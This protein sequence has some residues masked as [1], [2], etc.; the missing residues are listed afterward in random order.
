MYLLLKVKNKR[1]LLRVNQRVWLELF[2]WEEA[3]HQYSECTG[4]LGPTLS[5]QCTENQ[6]TSSHQD[7]RPVTWVLDNVRVCVRVYQYALAQ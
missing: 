7:S 5:L 6:H 1:L 3:L 4:Q 2:F